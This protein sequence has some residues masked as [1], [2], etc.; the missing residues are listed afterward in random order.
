MVSVLIPV[1]NREK[2]IYETIES[3]QSQSYQNWECILVDDGSTDNSIGVMKNMAAED[4]RLRI[5]ERPA[6]SKK[7]A[8]T[9][10]NL[11]F[12]HSQG[13]FIQYFDSDDLM[14]P[15]MLS[16]KVALLK[17]KPE[18]DFV[19]SK[20]GE[21]DDNGPIEFEDYHLFSENLTQDFLNYKVYFLTPGPLFKRSF[22]ES[23]EV[24][25][26]ELLDRRQ[27][28]EFYTRI[29]LS[30]PKYLYSDTIHCMRRIH[31]NSIKSI[32]DSIASIEQVKSK[33]NFYKQISRN[34]SFKYSKVLNEHH[35]KEV[36]R[37]ALVFIK[38]GQIRW[39]ALALKLYIDLI[40]TKN[41]VPFV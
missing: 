8:A 22:L 15:T 25:F 41:R 12:E 38:E 5:F 40:R 7:G 10:R 24:K 2:I 32:H 19:V 37:M 11:A 34:S 9:C 30:R 6:A 35:G 13:K 33:F 18:L 16:D 36:F 1:F 39:A 3:I 26:D 14:K 17:S 29:I 27:E 20:M 28:R 31:S 23:F 4:S 21:F